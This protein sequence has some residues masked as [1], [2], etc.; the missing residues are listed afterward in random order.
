M[1][2][3]DEL[4]VWLDQEYVGVLSFAAEWL[5][6]WECAKISLFCGLSAFSHMLS[7]PKEAGFPC[8][9]LCRLLAMNSNSKPKLPRACALPYLQRMRRR[10]TCSIVD[11]A[12]CRAWT[13][14]DTV[15]RA[16]PKSVVEEFIVV[17]YGLLWNTRLMGGHPV[18]LRCGFK[19]S[20]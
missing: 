8:R 20:S 16:P 9:P 6:G 15:S 18:N 2:I 17:E 3:Y 5:L 12:P 10:S 1:P 4:V 19:P 7:Q 13:P 11:H 14:A